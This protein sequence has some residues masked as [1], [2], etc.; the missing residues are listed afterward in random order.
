M[1]SIL[2]IGPHPDDQELGMGGAIARLA[3]QGHTVT[4]LDMTNGE[5]T[6]F[7]NPETR[8]REAAAAAR[9]LGGGV[10]GKVRRIQLGLRNRF[11][12]HSV[13]ARHKVA[14]VIRA[15]QAQVMFVPYFEDAHP[16]HLAVTRI[17]ED[18][19]FDAKLTGLAM[20]GDE[21]RPPLYPK[22]LFHYY[23]THLRITPRPSFYMDTTGF[24]QTKR[25]A[26]LAYHSQFVANTKNAPV[27]DWLD[28]AGRYFGSRIGTA[29]AEP[30]FAREPIGL[31]SL[32]G[33]VL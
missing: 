2:V 13:E 5:P 7:G 6:P 4:L 20:P 19:R 16:D 31:A 10:E 8:A 33:L 25:D 17:A 11:V 12:E 27:I 23:A 22:W 21:G 24:E 15:V 1:P 32:E 18:A 30:F 26:C 28:A 14:G 3:A 29:S 9:I